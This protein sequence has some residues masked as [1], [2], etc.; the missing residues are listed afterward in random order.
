MY[1]HHNTSHNKKQN[2]IPMYSGQDKHIGDV[3]GNEW[4]KDLFNRWML[5]TPPAIANDVQALHDAVR[6]GA[7]Y[8]VATNKDNGIIYRAA[9]AKILDKGFPVNRG[10]GN[11]IALALSD[12][13]QTRDPNLTQ[14]E[15]PAYT[16][17]TATDEVKPLKYKSNAP[18]GITFN[19][20][21]QMSLFEVK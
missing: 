8:L 3:I 12:W 6:A 14:T 18:T 16:E 7:E 17:A 2:G 1:K 5:T 4:R 20:V 10:Y 15:P 19:G 21:K 13:L 11:Q 9:I